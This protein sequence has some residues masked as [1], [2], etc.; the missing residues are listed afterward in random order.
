MKR[1]LLTTILAGAAV[2]SSASAQAADC[3][4]RGV[5]FDGWLARYQG[6]AIAAGLPAA[7]VEKALAGLTFD[8]AVIKKDR[9]QGVFSQTFATFAGRMVNAN[10]MSVGAKK[11][12]ANAALFRRIETQYGVPAEV[13]TAVWG[14]ESDFGA[15]TGTFATLRSL[16]TLSYDCRRPELFRGELMQALEIVARGDLTPA[17]MTG[18]WAGELG[19]MQFLPSNYVKY[20]VDEDGDGRRDLI[21][22]APD[23][24]ASTANY[25]NALGW[26]PGAPWLVEV[27]IPGNLPWDQADLSIKKPT[28]EWQAM[29]VAGAHGAIPAGAAALYLPMGRFGPAFLAYHNFDV[30]LGWNESLVYA[31][32]AAYFA[33]R[34]EGAPPVG[35]GNGP[36]EA[37]GA[38]DIAFVQQA[39]AR[40]GHDVGPI[41]GKLGQMTRE[42]V[43]DFQIKAGLPADGWPDSAL[44]KALR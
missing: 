21:R 44:L 22:S 4:A 19:Q 36:V 39:L 15:N 16:A 20:G 34:L 26:I 3:D 17:E 30:Y 2:L 14:L 6:Q 42:A 33:T 32:T 11:I 31:T 40:Q 24:I 7:A 43:R 28:S 13:I 38:G 37:L 5:G 1:S 10:R 25:L 23:A 27:S 8:P 18:A 9:G 29:G 35:K 41:D 12:A